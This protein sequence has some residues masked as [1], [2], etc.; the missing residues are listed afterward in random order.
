M[1]TAVGLPE[2]V[3]Y[4]E[5]EYEALILELATDRERLKEIRERL[6]VN[7]LSKPLFKS[8]ENTKLLEN[9]LRQAYELYFDGK[10]PQ[11]IWCTAD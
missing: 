7:R 11:D 8:K 5:E 1:L 10:Q 6:A 9:G 4:N 3:T 2:L